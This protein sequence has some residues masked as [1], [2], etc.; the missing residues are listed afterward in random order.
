MC[1]GEAG[2]MIKCRRECED[3]DNIGQVRWTLRLGSLDTSR[4]PGRA[5]FRAN[6]R[7]RLI[8][9]CRGGNPENFF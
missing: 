8:V 3:G 6:G 4:A 9:S 5:H 7:S 2:M 1:V